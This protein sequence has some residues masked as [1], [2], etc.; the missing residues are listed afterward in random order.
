[1]TQ[2]EFFEKIMYGDVITE[3]MRTH[4][5]DEF[6]KL[7]QKENDKIKEKTFGCFVEGVVSKIPFQR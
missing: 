1:M 4:A 5:A 2:K 3:E 6:E 7:K